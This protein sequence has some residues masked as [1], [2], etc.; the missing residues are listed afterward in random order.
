[1]SYLYAG[2]NEVSF[3]SVFSIK[4]AKQSAKTHTKPYEIVNETCKPSSV[5]K[6]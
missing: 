5:H 4:G 3:L 6:V 1:M 2:G